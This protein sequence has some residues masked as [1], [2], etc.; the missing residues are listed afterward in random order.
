MLF[1]ERT[2]QEINF[3]A[4]KHLRRFPFLKTFDHGQGNKRGRVSP[5]FISKHANTWDAKQMF[6]DF[7]L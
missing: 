4:R 6:A 2:S 5:K 3:F 1:V 7:D